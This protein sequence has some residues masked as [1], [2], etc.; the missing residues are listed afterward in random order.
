LKLPLRLALSL[1]IAAALLAVLLAVGGV[2]PSQMLRGLARLS[3]EVYA[4]ALLL[5]VVVYL[6]RAVRFRV[7]LPADARLGF[8]RLLSITASYTMASVILPAKVGE[9]SFV[10]YAGRVGGVPAADA[11]ACLLVARLLDFATLTLGMAAACLALAATHAYP[12]IPWLAPLGIALLPA[13]LLLFAASARGDLLVRFASAASRLLGFGK[14]QTGMRVLAA[15]E[16]IGDALRACSARGRL[17]SAA[18]LS[19][20]AWVCV[21]L[22]CAILARGLGLPPETT[23]AQAT[24]GSGL[25]ILTTLVPV[26]AFA[27]VG[28]LEAGWVLG[29]TSLGVPPELATSTGFGLHLVQ[30]ANT[31]LLGVLGHVGMALLRDRPQS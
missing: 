28:T 2:H 30:I 21:F 25:A 24:F 23:F 27:N 14:T 4:Y 19:L 17:L 6:F 10:V 13:A 26:S 31:V 1:G 8:P 7:L 29:F 18:V 15:S 16:R 20:A 9:A 3:F 11:F 5:T 22:Y 12:G